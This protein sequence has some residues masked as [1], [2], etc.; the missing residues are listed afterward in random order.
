MKNI[1]GQALRVDSYQYWFMVIKITLGENNKL[2]AISDAG[3]SYDTEITELR[4][5]IRIRMSDDGLIHLC[6]LPYG[7][8]SPW[9][10]YSCKVKIIVGFRVC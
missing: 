8:C 2:L 10:H 4:R 3:K 9:L 6:I 1:P 7:H 5:Q